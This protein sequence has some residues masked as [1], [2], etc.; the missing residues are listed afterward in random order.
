MMLCRDVI[1]RLEEL[2]PKSLACEWDNPG[3][4]VGREDQE[5]HKVL[6]ALDATDPVVD[7]AVREQADLLVT[8]HPMI[9]KGV[10]QINSQSFTGRR[11]LTL[12]EHR[13]GCFAMHTNFD[14]APGCMA[15]LAA[16]RLGILDGQPLEVTGEVDGQPVGIGK[17]GYLK[18]PMSL[19]ELAVRVKEAFG[20]SFV[21]VYGMEGVQEPVTRVAVSPGSGGSML[22]HGIAAGAQVLVTGDIGH[23]QGID[24]V[25][26]HMAVIDGGHY[27]LEHLFIPFMK[28][29]LERMSQGAL[30]VIEAAPAFPAEV[31]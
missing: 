5:I 13:I 15:D 4:L 12:A 18:A 22:K 2:A 25:A 29:Y 16:Q 10:K 6:V 23:H 11:I 14:I 28:E 30:Q 20:L 17:V 8:H 19:K 24:A 3:L 9:F 7:Q 26:D 1:Q 31:L 21:T 27:G